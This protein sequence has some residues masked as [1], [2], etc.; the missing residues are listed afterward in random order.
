METVLQ[1]LLGKECIAEPI[2]HDALGRNEVYYLPD[3]NAIL[4]VYGESSRWEREIAALNLLQGS[5]LPVPRVLEY[6]MLDDR[7]H[8]VMMSRLAGCTLDRIPGLD[9]EEDRAQIVKEVGRIHAQLHINSRLGSFGDWDRKGKVISQSSSYREFVTERNR[10]QAR[11]TISKGYPDTPLFVDAFEK[12]MTLEHTATQ[13]Q[14]F[15]LCHHD[16]GFRNVLVERANDKWLVSGIIDFEMSFPADPESDLAGMLLQTYFT[17]ERRWYVDGYQ[18]VRRLSPGFQC[19]IRYYLI[20]L[21]L[22]VCSWSYEREP[23]YYCQAID[24]LNDL[25]S[26]P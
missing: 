15:S 13:C 10:R 8:W 20:A 12:L 16:F 17:D 9:T 19:K 11:R 1:R 23:S 14:Q 4:K 2:A 6:G 21:C 18:E 22:E 24:V 5:G 3:K 26:A 7:L 25:L